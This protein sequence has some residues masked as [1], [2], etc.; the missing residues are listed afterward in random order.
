MPDTHD[1]DGSAVY[2]LEKADRDIIPGKD[3]T[4][5]TTQDE[6]ATMLE[7]T[8]LTGYTAFTVDGMMNDDCDWT[9]ADT[10][11]ITIKA[12]YKK[13]DSDATETAVPGTAKQVTLASAPSISTSGVI[14]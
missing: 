2:K 4:L 7:V 12:V 1:A 6:L 5:A 13:M 9:K 11:A 14:P 10:K 3:I 8:G